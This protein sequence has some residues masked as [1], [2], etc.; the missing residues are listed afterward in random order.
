MTVIWSVLKVIRIHQHAKF[1]AIPPMCSPEN[2]RNPQLWLVSLTQN[3]AEMRKIQTDRHEILISSEGGQYTS[4]HQISGHSSYASSRK[5]QETT[6]LACF[7]KSK[8]CQN[9]ENTNR[10]WPKSNQ[11][12]RW[13]GYISMSNF[14]AFLP[15]VLQKMPGNHNFDLFNKV[16]A[17][18]LSGIHRSESSP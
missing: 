13:S 9:E 18:P 1:Q 6:I 7:A 4:A 2:A 5:C 17:P 8:R 16:K 3:A 15:C 14:R 10:P 11:F 12:W